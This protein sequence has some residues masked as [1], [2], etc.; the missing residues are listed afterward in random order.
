MD[1]ASI[2]ENVGLR[3]M[4]TN[5]VVQTLML[6]LGNGHRGESGSQPC[7]LAEDQIAR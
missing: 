7:S 4:Y 6:S 3:N 2:F 5:E 1:I